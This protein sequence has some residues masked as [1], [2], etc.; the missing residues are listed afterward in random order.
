MNGA[1]TL[2][3]SGDLWSVI[4]SVRVSLQIVLDAF[5]LEEAA[6][7]DSAP[8]PC[9]SY[10]RGKQAS[11]FVGMAELQKQLHVSKH[12]AKSTWCLMT[13]IAA[14]V[15]AHSVRMMVNQLL[16]RPLFHLADLAV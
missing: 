16:G 3:A 9:V 2:A 10:K 5:Q 12:Y 14:K 8:V 7:I 4:L 11:D 1:V 6:A 15:T 13:R